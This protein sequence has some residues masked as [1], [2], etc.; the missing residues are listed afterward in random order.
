MRRPVAVIAAAAFVLTVAPLAARAA[1]APSITLLSP[2]D[3]DVATGEIQVTWSYEGFS[4]K[5]WVD[6]QVKQGDEDYTRLE[7]LRIDDGTPG[8]HG[9][10]TWVTEPADDGADYAL[11]VIVPSNKKVHDSVTLVVDNT[12]PEATEV[13]RTPAPNAAGWNNGDV[14]VRWTC[15]DPTSPVLAEEVVAT[16]V[17]EGRDLSATATCEN[18]AGLITDAAAADIDIDRTAPATAITSPKAAD[19]TP[20]VPLGVVIAGTA[21]DNL[22]GVHAVEVTFVAADGTETRRPASCIQC[23][24]GSAVW[25]VSTFGLAPGRYTVAA[26]AVDVADNVGKA[27][28]ADLLLLA[29]V[30][31]PASVEP[32]AP[33]E[34]PAPPTAPEPPAA[35]AAPSGTAENDSTYEVTVWVES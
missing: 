35:P 28:T 18:R 9:S 25:T 16:V 4:P 31:D 6:V 12:P 23:G 14:T 11:R 20:A 5:A 22:S 3:G 1:F 19:D 10:Y 15:T 8:N 27:S 32:P 2:A 33:P 29:S 7:R 34:A 21:D 26:T 17:G 24:T 13:E 30:A